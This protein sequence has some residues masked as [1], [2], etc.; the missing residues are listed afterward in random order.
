MSVRLYEVGGLEELVKKGL[1][2]SVVSGNDLEGWDYGFRG[3]VCLKLKSMSADSV[4]DVG[5]EQEGVGDRA[6][7]FN[8]CLEEKSQRIPVYT[9]RPIVLIWTL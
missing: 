3:R 4:D 8:T 7:P 6:N 2:H 9:K 5:L 1:R